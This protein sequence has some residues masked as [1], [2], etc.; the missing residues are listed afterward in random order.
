MTA[1]V[2]VHVNYT[3]TYTSFEEN[4]DLFSSTVHLLFE[5]FMFPEFYILLYHLTRHLTV[6]SFIVGISTPLI[7]QSIESYLECDTLPLFFYQSI[8]NQPL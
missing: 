7:L 6:L 3:T 2:E 1:L 5:C 8:K 4:C